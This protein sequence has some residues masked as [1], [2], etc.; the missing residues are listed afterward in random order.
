MA[1]SELRRE[2][3]AGVDFRVYQSAGEV[4]G[5][6]G[7]Q[8]VKDVTLI[9][10]AYV[11]QERQRQRIG[12]LLLGEL[13]ERASRPVLVGT[14]ADASWAIRFYEKNGFTLVSPA[15]KDRLLA[16]YWTVPRR[17]AEVSV[18]LADGAALKALSID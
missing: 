18:V 11:I 17:Q 6:M 16:S 1:A 15:A 4:V 2:L 10:H 7:V 3:L 12:S 14:W 8:D 13:R 5:V 9:R